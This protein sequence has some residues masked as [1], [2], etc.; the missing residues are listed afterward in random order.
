[1][2][3]PFINILRFGEENKVTDADELAK[4]NAELSA[5]QLPTSRGGQLK[6]MSFHPNASPGA[7]AGGQMW[8]NEMASPNEKGKKK[9][10]KR[11]RD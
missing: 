11:N 5:H 9:K 7:S 6:R 10:T 1:M 8:I 4:A 2:L 3:H